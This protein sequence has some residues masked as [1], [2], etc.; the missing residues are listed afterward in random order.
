MKRST[1]CALAFASVAVTACSGGQA[2]KCVGIFTRSEPADGATEDKGI[3]G[4]RVQR[5][6]PILS[7]IFGRKNYKGTVIVNLSPDQGFYSDTSSGILSVTG[8]GDIISASAEDRGSA[9]LYYDSLTET[10][11]YDFDQSSFAGRCHK[12]T[13][14]P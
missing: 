2:T 13:G 1:I 7:S 9:F 6:V 8:D 12:I 5:P 14:A 3:L 10:I 4:F 11:R